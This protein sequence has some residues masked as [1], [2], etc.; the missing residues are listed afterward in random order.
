MSELPFPLPSEHIPAGTVAWRSA[1]AAQWSAA[2]PRR[3]AHPLGAVLALAVGMVWFVVSA[4][5]EACTTARPCASSWPNITMTVLALLCLY[6]VWRQPLLA[7]GGLG[8]LFAAVLVEA[9][10]ALSDL[11]A[12]GIAL[13]GALGFA[14]VTVVHRVGSARRQRTLAEAAAGDV[15]H[16]LPDGSGDFK[17]GR[18][19]LVVGV[20]LLAVSAFALWRAL[21]VVSGYEDRAAGAT[22]VSAKVV[23][24]DAVDVDVSTL[25]VEA[26]DGQRRHTLDTVF[27]EDYPVGTSVD[28]VVDGDWVRLVAEPYDIFDWELLLV[29]SS[30]PGLAFL[31]NGATGHLRARSLNGRAL[32]AL[33]VLVHEGEEDARTYVYAA[34]DLAAE[35]PLL[36]FHSLY[37]TEAGRLPDD[38]ARV[39]TA[40]EESER[41]DALLASGKNPPLREA[42]LLGAPYAGAE[43]AFLAP[44]PTGKTEQVDVERSVTPVRPYALGPLSPKAYGRA[45]APGQQPARRRARRRPVREVAD[46]MRP[47]TAPRSWT[48]DGG[49]RGVGV[50]LLAVQGITLAQLLVGDWS[51]YKVLALFALPYFITIVATALNWRLTAD[52]GGVWVRGGWRVR[53]VRWERIAGVRHAHDTVEISIS[54]SRDEI[55]L[56]PVS[57]GWF[58]RRLGKGSAAADAT[59]A[60]RAMLHYPELRPTEDAESR[61]QGAPLG[62]VIAGF[63]LVWAAAVLLL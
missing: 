55:E 13:L 60:L 51:W 38:E 31:L 39:E 41:F 56:M 54:G 40:E 4:P 20:L 23:G 15:R 6:G 5:E 53:H 50:F 34:D 46:G 14:V 36:T 52:R 35:R 58:Q 61:D 33:R 59:E 21:D 32:P 9:D 12:G 30:V 3:W 63:T 11:G 17:R 37:A 48:A 2:A 57:A 29:L 62:P 18:L 7:L 22:R 1:D 42:V 49:S 8:T 25:V 19:S 27:P 45:K 16:Q 10:F 28:L 24:V 43:V 44:E 26:R 47:T